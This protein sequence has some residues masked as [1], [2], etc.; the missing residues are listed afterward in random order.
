MSGRWE[1]F[2]QQFVNRFVGD[3]SMKLKVY[4]D[5]NV[6]TFP[7]LPAVG[8]SQRLVTCKVTNGRIDLSALAHSGLDCMSRVAENLQGRTD[9]G[10]H[11]TSE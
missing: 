9:L 5:P 2:A 1:M 10:P 11:P 7:G 3:S 8:D 6:V 4:L